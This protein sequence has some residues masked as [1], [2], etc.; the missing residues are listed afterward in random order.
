MIIIKHNCLL[1]F[2]SC[3][4]HFLNNSITKKIEIIEG[5]FRNT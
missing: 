5:L 3:E 2:Q 4:M 1:M